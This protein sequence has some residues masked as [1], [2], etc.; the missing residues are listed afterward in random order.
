MYRGININT[1]LE[2]SRFDGI[3]GPILTVTSYDLSDEHERE[4]EMDL[5]SV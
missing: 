2:T 3:Q 4:K 1:Y 5:H